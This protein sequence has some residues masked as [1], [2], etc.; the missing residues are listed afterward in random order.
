MHLSYSY[1]V[2]KFNTVIELVELIWYKD[3]LYTFMSQQKWY[4]FLFY[5]SFVLQ[6]SHFIEHNS[7]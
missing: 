2:L 3:Y 5:Q 6:L 4:F 1:V 7:L